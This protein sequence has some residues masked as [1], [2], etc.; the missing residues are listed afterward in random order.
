[1]TINGVPLKLFAPRYWP[2]WLGVIILR[3]L[4]FLPYPAMLKTS[5]FIGTVFYPLAKR[6]T[7][8]IEVNIRL[9]FPDKTPQQQKQMA[10]E[11]L[12]S[13]VMAIF[14]IALAWWGSDKVVN[15]LLY[16]VKGHEH[17]EAAK[18]KGKGVILLV[19]HFTT[20]EL[21]GVF[22]NREIGNVKYVYK[23]STNELIEYFI[24][25]KRLQKGCA[26][27][28]K[29]KNLREIIRSLKRG[30]TIWY[31]PDQDFGRKDSVFAPFMGVAT[32]T[33]LSTQRLARLTG[34]PVVPYYLARLDGSKGY[35]MR[36]SPALE[37][38]PS[39]DEVHDAT[40]INRAI[41]K[42]IALAPEQYLWGHRRFKTRPEGEKDVY[43][44]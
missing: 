40:L 21:A 4:A 23:R 28:I 17:Y 16:N 6:R 35:E 30:E 36:I 20:M 39:D 29:H 14:E 8:I 2:V 19:S 10:K 44:S 26:E 15:N 24:R 5:R 37:D 33:L 1:M 32:S 38:F 25:H 13:G 18:K 22:L 11:A 3:L 43:T 31:A 12:I 42:Q 9:C 27:L 34:A 41:E 7:R